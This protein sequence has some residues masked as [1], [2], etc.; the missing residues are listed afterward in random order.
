[1]ASDRF[2]AEHFSYFE[3]RLDAIEK[4][5][6]ENSK[7]MNTRMDEHFISCR[8]LCVTRISS[9]ISD[10]NKAHERLNKQ[11]ETIECLTAHKNKDL[12]F[13]RA[14]SILLTVLS[15]LLGYLG[16]NVSWKN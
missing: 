12:G 5:I 8:E 4:A 6:D 9:V 7:V 3:A 13:R 1:M 16:L 11:K 10:T 2:T 14:F 15:L